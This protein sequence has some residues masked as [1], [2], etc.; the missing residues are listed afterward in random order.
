M[1]QVVA[2]PPLPRRIYIRDFAFLR[3]F[4]SS[5]PRYQYA[6]VPRLLQLKH[7]LPSGRITTVTATK[8]VTL[9]THDRALSATGT[10]VL[11]FMA[12]QNPA[13]QKF[14]P[15]LERVAERCA[16]VPFYMADSEKE[17]ELAR[18]HHVRTLPM[19]IFYRDGNPIRRVPGVLSA[20]ELTSVVEEVLHA[21]MRQE[22]VEL[23]V[24]IVRTQEPLSPVLRQPVN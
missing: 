21:D 1:A 14:R 23:L 9:V 20:D 17:T 8:P 22:I 16:S 13:C 19:S 11:V 10:A 18:L 7:C 12:G 3:S 6:L 24:E 4:R 5:D 2:C 15:T